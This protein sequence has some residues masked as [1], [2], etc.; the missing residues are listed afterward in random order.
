VHGCKH[1]YNPGEG[2][3]DRV[4]A[5]EF[6]LKVFRRPKYPGIVKSNPSGDGRVKA[7]V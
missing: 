6:I 7:R 4:E 2:G 1:R 3:I 5:T